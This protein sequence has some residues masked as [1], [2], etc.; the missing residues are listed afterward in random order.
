MPYLNGGEGGLLILIGM[1]ELILKEDYFLKPRF[2]PEFSFVFKARGDLVTCSKVNLDFAV[3]ICEF[4]VGDECLNE[5]CS[6]YRNQ[7]LM[8]Q[9]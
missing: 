7:E 8:G 6:K 5:L 3:E 4:S 1:T 9:T 2:H